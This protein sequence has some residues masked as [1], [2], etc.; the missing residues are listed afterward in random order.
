MR[1]S[2]DFLSFSSDLCRNM[3][4]SSQKNQPQTGMYLIAFF[5]APREQPSTLVFSRYHHIT[6]QSISDEWF[7]NIKWCSF[8]KQAKSSF[9]QCK[10]NSELDQKSI[11]KTISER[12]KDSCAIKM[13]IFLK[14][15]TRYPWPENEVHQLI[16]YFFVKWLDE[17][18]KDEL[19][20][21]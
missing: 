3:W 20:C 12:I 18:Q 14:L 2:I 16:K 7:N 21:V 19:N 9:V 10:I 8:P 6:S 1:S 17:H 15:L 5:I 4:S 11:M 13:C